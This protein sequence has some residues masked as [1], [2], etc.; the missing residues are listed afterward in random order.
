MAESATRYAFSELRNAD[1][2]ESTIN[3]LNS[4]TYNVTDSGTFNIRAFSL[5][6]EALSSTGNTHTLII[7]KGRLPLGV[8][9]PTDPTNPKVWAINLEYRNQDTKSSTIKGPITNYNRINDRRL[10]IELNFEVSPGERVGL[11]V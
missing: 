9:I 6:F 11:A 4:T 8:V 10:T 2:A 5:W 3:D 7:P 1:F